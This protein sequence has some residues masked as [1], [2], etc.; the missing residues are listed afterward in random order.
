MLVF[1][2]NLYLI[3]FQKTIH[4]R[5]DLTAC[6]LIDNLVNEWGGEIILGTGLIQI[7]EV[8]TYVNHSL[9]FVDQNRI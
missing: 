2:F 8:H 6:T 4:E 9:L 3:A 5:K 1:G 7:T